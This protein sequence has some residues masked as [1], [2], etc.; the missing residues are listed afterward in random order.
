MNN[1]ALQTWKDAPRGKILETDVVVAKNYLD[2]E[3]KRKSHLA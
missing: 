2:K 3:E 1:I